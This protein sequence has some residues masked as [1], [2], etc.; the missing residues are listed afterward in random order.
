[1]VPN[2]I[3]SNPNDPAIVQWKNVLQS[4]INGMDNC[5]DIQSAISCES[6]IS[7]IISNCKSHPNEL[8]ACNDTRFAK[9]AS[10][11]KTAQEIEEQRIQAAQEGAE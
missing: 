10:L 6:S 7:T 5:L 2:Q 9:Y 11:L 8:L 4:A 1:N 3:K